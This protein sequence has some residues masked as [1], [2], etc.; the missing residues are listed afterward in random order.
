MQMMAL[1]LGIHLRVRKP[2]HVL[3]VMLQT[4]THFLQ[5]TCEDDDL[6]D[7]RISGAV[8]AVLAQCALQE[9]HVFIVL[10]G[11]DA[12]GTATNVEDWLPPTK[13]A[14]LHWIVTTSHAPHVKSLTSLRNFDVL[15]ISADSWD[16]QYREGLLQSAIKRHKPAVYREHLEKLKEA[17]LRGPEYLNSCMDIMRTCTQDGQ[18]NPLA[19]W[20]TSF[21]T[22]NAFH[23][24]ILHKWCAEVRGA[25]DLLAVLALAETGMYEHELMQLLEVPTRLPCI[26]WQDLLR[27]LEEA[28]FVCCGI[29]TFFNRCACLGL[30]QD[31]R[32][33]SVLYDAHVQLAATC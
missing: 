30:A 6:L 19:E 25:Q 16:E 15:S 9:R 14:N 5:A 28:T 7:E 29:R 17:P 13:A 20:C 24:S 22:I 31:T 12:L 26:C 32:V 1:Y 8:A 4:L 3:R 11:L 21:Q 23:V 27:T 10:D 33:C 18:A 2:M